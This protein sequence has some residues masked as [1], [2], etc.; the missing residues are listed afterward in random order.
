M[1]EK[2]VTSLRGHI[3]VESVPASYCIIMKAYFAAQNPEYFITS[4]LRKQVTSSR[5]TKTVRN[6]KNSIYLSID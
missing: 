2:N 4:T 3:R 5:H 6:D 1:E